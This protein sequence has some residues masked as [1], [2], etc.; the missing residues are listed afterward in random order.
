M[1]EKTRCGDLTGQ[2]FGRLKVLERQVETRNGVRQ[3]F[4]LCE[5]SCGSTKT[6]SHSNLRGNSKSCGC[7]RREKLSKD[8]RGQLDDVIPNQIMRYYKR[9]A[10]TRNIDWALSI[11]QVK[12]LIFNPCHYCGQVGVSETVKKYSFQDDLVHSLRNNG[13]DRVDSSAGYMIDNVV[14][15]CKFCNTAKWV[16]SEKEFLRWV[17]LVYRHSVVR[18][19]K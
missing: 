7:L 13:I 2:T 6:V 16:Q 8:R 4:Y 15:C 10:K 5:C 1:I 18:E 19:L 17:E 12:S 3:V 14:P 11:E 9:N